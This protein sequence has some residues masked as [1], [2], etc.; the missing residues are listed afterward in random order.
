MRIFWYVI[1][2][3][4]SIARISDE[5]K[6]DLEDLVSSQYSSVRLGTVLAMTYWRNHSST[7]GLG[8]SLPTE[9]HPT[10]EIIPKPAQHSKTV[11]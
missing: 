6:P 3:L 1:F 2:L 8:L 4:C 9:Y 7:G 10:T 5:K 11:Y